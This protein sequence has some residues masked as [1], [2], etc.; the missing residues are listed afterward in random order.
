MSA[1]KVTILLWVAAMLQCVLPRWPFASGLSWPL[2]GAAILCISFQHTRSILIYSVIL[3]SLLHDSLMP[4]PLGISLPY[5]ALLGGLVYLLRDELFS[6]HLLTY[7]LLGAVAGCFR[8][9]YFDAVLSFAGLRNIDFSE[10]VTHLSAGA[11]LGMVTAPIVY[12][13]LQLKWTR[14]EKVAF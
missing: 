2:L 4:V 11:I 10:G 12:K 8:S 13:A 14:K 9:I 5:F 6:D 3:A 7:F 1:V